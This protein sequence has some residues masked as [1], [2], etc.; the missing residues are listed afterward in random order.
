MPPSAGDP[1]GLANCTE[2][3]WLVPVPAPHH[4]MW[5]SLGQVSAGFGGTLASLSSTVLPSSQVSVPSTVLFPHFGMVSCETTFE[6]HSES[7]MP[8]TV[9]ASPM[10]APAPSAL[11]NALAKLV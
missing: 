8:S 7:T 6:T 3:A 10:Q 2:T 11:A 1:L 9:S 4:P 5:Q